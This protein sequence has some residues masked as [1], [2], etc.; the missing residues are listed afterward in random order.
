MQFHE[1]S[2]IKSNI[3]S[4]M[5]IRKTYDKFGVLTR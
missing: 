2:M 4:S 3:T 1:V 5:D